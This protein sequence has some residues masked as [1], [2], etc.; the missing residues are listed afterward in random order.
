MLPFYS[1]NN[2]FLSHE[3]VGQFVICNPPW[4]L[5]VQCVEHLRKCH[6]KSPTNTKAVIVLPE[7][8]QFIFVTIGLKLLVEQ[9]PI[10]T[11]V[12]TKPSP[13]GI[14][15]QLIKVLWP[16]N[17]WI[18]DKDTPVGVPST[19]V[20]SVSSPID[21]TNITNQSDIASHWLPSAVALTIMDPNKPELLMKLPI[22]IEYDSLR[23]DASVLIDSTATLNFVSQEFFFRNGLVGKCVR[24]PKIAARIANNEQR[25]STNKYFSPTSLFIHQ[26]KFTGQSFTL[27]PHIK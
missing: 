6:A 26:I 3:V 9:I 24:G 16:I 8:P 25:I 22:S 17:Y 15:N 5:V 14:R 20:Q 1:K 18:I 19:H 11:P 10:D 21:I 7:W 27:F 12:F 13:L 2:S 4:S 23:Y